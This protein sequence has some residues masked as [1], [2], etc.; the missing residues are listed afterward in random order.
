MI[1]ISSKRQ[2]DFFSILVHDN[3]SGIPPEKLEQLNDYI[4]EKNENFSGVGLRNV[5]KRIKL[6][7]GEKYGLI[8]HSSVGKGTTVEIRLPYGEYVDSPETT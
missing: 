4:N 1:T 3:G 8:I 5:N 7:M 2:S 6:R